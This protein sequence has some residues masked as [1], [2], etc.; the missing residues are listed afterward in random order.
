MISYIL[1]DPN[2][3]AALRAETQSSIRNGD[4][5]IFHLMNNCPRLNAVFLKTLRV[6]S[7]ALSARKVVAP[8]PLGDKV[9][10]SGNTV[11]IPLRQLH[12][13]ETVFGQDSQLFDPERFLKNKGLRNSSSF[14]PFG[15]GV[16]HC[17]GQVLAKQEML[18][19]VA[20]LLNRFKLELTTTAVHEN[21]LSNAQCFPMLD[22]STPSLGVNGPAKGS[23]VFV[24]FRRHET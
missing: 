3:L 14:R 20:L 10:G 5:D 18:V 19:F 24:N 9:L 16:S 7:G 21:P 12:C 1:F 15:G 4:I 6:T 8:T 13:D 2:L 23:N 17:L 11:L 22:E